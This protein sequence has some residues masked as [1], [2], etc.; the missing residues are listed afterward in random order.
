MS[1]NVYEWVQDGYHDG[2]EGE[3]TNGS[4]W[5]AKGDRVTRGETG[6]LPL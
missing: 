1:G 2:Y 4:A 3:P 6:Q 5:E